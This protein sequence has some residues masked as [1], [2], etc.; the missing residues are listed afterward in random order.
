MW[1]WDFLFRD[2]NNIITTPTATITTT[3]NLYMSSSE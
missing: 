1:L 3:T 2:S